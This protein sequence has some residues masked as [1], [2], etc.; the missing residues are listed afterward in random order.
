M[1]VL[2]V[3]SAI[4]A[5]GGA[6]YGFY[7]SYVQVNSYNRITWTFWPYLML[8]LG[9]A[10][11]N[12]GALLGCIVFVVAR[13]L[14][15]FYKDAFV[16]FLPFDPVWLDYVMLGIVLLIMLTRRPQGILP[17]KSTATMRRSEFEKIK[18]SLDNRPS[19]KTS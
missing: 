9:G 18:Q 13:R 19:E 3:G 2:F 16:A 4:S 17:E 10:G 12:E 14:I 15:N 11:N 6:L 7:S 5:L 8:I 1:K